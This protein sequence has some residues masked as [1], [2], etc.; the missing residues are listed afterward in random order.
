MELVVIWDRRLSSAIRRPLRKQQLALSSG[1]LVECFERGA[2]PFQSP[3]DR[4]WSS[5][6]SNSEVLR[7]LEKLSGHYAGLELLAQHPHKFGGTAHPEPRKHCSAEAA[8]LT[9]EVR[10][11]SQEFVNQNTIRFQQRPGAIAHPIEIVEGYHCEELGGMDWTS[12]CESND[13]PHALYQLRLRQNPST[14]N[15]AQPIRFG[16]ASRNNEIRSQ[17]KFGTPRLVEDGLEIRIIT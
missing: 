5:A 7:L 13:L 16:Q 10:M 11:S 2:Q 12:V 15:A 1:C 8:W 6:K 17:M 3:A 9:I 14:A 4:L